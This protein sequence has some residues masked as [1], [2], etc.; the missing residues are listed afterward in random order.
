MRI[1]K[2]KLLNFHRLKFL[3][4]EGCSHVVKILSR[5]GSSSVRTP[6]MKLWRPEFDNLPLSHYI[7]FLN[8]TVMPH[9]TYFLLSSAI[10]ASFHVMSVGGTPPRHRIKTS[11]SN[12]R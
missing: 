4:F 6:L 3:P 12:F 1:K 5:P 9:Y 10:V 2:G 8:Q 11:K 7:P